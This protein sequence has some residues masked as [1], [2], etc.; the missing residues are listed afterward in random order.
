MKVARHNMVSLLWKFVMIHLD[1]YYKSN[2][3][4]HLLYINGRFLS[5]IIDGINDVTDPWGRCAYGG[6]LY[7]GK[8]KNCNVIK[9][10][11]Y[12]EKINH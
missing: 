4:V 11:S 10:F 8:K 5:M 6:K 9:V 12:L 1:T 3:S 2:P 7:L